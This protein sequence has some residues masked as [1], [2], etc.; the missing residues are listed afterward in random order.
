MPNINGKRFFLFRSVLNAILLLN[1]VT[2]CSTRQQSSEQLGLVWES[3]EIV[4][5]SYVGSPSLNPE[6]VTGKM[7]DSMLEIG[8]KP[9]YP[10][11]SELKDVSRRTPRDV[12]QELTDIWRAWVLFE[13][14]WPAIPK[15]Q[16]AEAAIQ[17]MMNALG[18]GSARHLNADAYI[19]AQ[20]DLSGNYD[21]IGAIVQIQDNYPT[22]VDLM[23]NEPAEKAGLQPGDVIHA[24]DGQSVKGVALE[25][26]IKLVRGTTGTKVTLLVGR[27]GTSELNEFTITRGAIEI[28]S[29]DMQLLPGGIAYIYIAEFRETTGDEVLDALEA[30]N[31]TD[32]M[33][34]ILDLRGNQGGSLEA[35]KDVASQFIND[36]LFMYSLDKDDTR[37]DWVITKGAAYKEDLLLAVVVSE[38][39]A[40]AAEALT[41]ALQDRRDAAV[42]GVKTSGRGSAS[43]YQEL[44]DGSALYIPIERWFTPYGYLFYRN[45]II[46]DIIVDITQ[47][48][49]AQGKDSQVV[50]AYN[51]LDNLLPPFR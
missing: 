24:V 35:A 5:A 28:L 29:V 25:E 51:Y 44:S 46:P 7:I 16:R 13:E 48:D 3:W 38:F 30:L 49:F 23:N 45:G 31:S 18:D 50:E 26:A 43:A 40:S 19:R 1:L 4:Q 36:G 10:F 12:P 32:F 9:G 27:P 2:S 37:E 33:A 47:E 20:E 6:M 39:T 21:G 22:I 17:G 42:I 14:K 11:L 34:L 41:G 15:Q 8:D